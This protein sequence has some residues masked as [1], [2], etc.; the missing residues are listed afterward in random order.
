M[1]RITLSTIPLTIKKVI[2]DNLEDIQHPIIWLADS[3][4]TIPDFDFHLLTP[5]VEGADSEELDDDWHSP[6]VGMF[7]EHTS[8]SFVDGRTSH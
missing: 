8:H 6:F 7:S 5:G 3:N 4:D 1:A 2:D